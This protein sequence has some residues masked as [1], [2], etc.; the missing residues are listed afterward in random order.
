[1]VNSKYLAPFINSVKDLFKT[2]FSCE[3]KDG[4]I[5]ASRNFPPNQDILAIIELNGRISGTVILGFS[6]Q[7]ALAMMNKLLGM[8][9]QEVNDEV[10]DT[11]SEFVNMAA[12][13]A[14]ANFCRDFEVPIEL[15]LPKVLHKKDFSTEFLSKSGWTEILFTGPFGSFILG[16]SIQSSHEENL[17]MKALIVD[18][19]Q[20]MRNMIIS[21]L[22]EIGPAECVQAKD[23]AE[24]VIAVQDDFFDIIFM[25]WNMPT[26]SGLEAVKK[27]R[28]SGKTMPIIMVTTESEKL[29][30]IE[31]I[32]AG[33]TS[34]ITKPFDRATLIEKIRGIL[35]K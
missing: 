4:R 3:V 1:M 30:V 2:M 8:H 28:A 6:E 20:F 35:G 27:I 13:I 19:A 23:G 18:D 29:R 17:G 33:A 31:A 21:V 34:Y 11:I 32:K 24:A 22:T 26:M 16:L 9:T 15:G 12:G 5:G 7:S 14:K 10:I 25:D